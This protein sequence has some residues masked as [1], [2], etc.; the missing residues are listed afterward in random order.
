MTLSLSALNSLTSDEA[1]VAKIDQLFRDH[2]LMA[3]S[4]ARTL[5]AKM[6]PALREK[7]LDGLSRHFHPDGT[8]SDLFGDAFTDIRMKLSNDIED[9]ASEMRAAE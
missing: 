5:S 8:A 1:T 2:L 6:D 4:E 3:L 9:A 7:L